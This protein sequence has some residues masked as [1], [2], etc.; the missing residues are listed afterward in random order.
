MHIAATHYTLGTHPVTGAG[1]GVSASD[2]DA[3][4]A[5][6]VAS[7]VFDE[8]GQAEIAT[9]L[10]GLA[11]TDFAKGNLETLLSADRNPE[12]W[13]VGEALAECFLTENRDC[14]FPWPDGRDERKRGSSLPG[15]DLGGVSAG[16]ADREVCIRRS[17]NIG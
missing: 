8:A 6:P 10:S 7:I 5:G 2:L 4:L 17:K 16:R 9:L 15:A 11:D 3:V 13:R 14:H 1:L 12:D